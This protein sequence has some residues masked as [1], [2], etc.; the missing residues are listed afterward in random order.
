M[1]WWGKGETSGG[2]VAKADEARGPPRR[3]PTSLPAGLA[4]GSPARGCRGSGRGPEH[5]PDCHP[6]WGW[7]VGGWG[8]GGSA[9]SEKE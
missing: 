8:G 4:F 5:T 6:G 1:P 9:S 3:A 2:G 7:G